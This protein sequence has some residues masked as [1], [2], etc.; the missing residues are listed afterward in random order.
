MILTFERLSGHNFVNV[1]FTPINTSLPTESIAWMFYIRKPSITLEQVYCEKITQQNINTSPPKNS[2]VCDLVC[3]FAIVKKNTAVNNLRTCLYLVY[4]FL[5]LVRGRLL[6]LQN[7]N[8]VFFLCLCVTGWC[9]I[10]FTGDFLLME[11]CVIVLVTLF[12]HSS[13]DSLPEECTQVVWWFG[14][15]GGCARMNPKFHPTLT[16]KS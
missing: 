5:P 7:A 2:L 15:A 11:C 8:A 3:V 13:V 16:S 10:I 4:V 12:V 9:C 14:Y 1:P 6:T